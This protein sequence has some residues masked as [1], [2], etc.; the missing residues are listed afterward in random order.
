MRMQIV[1]VRMV[2]VGFKLGKFYLLTD[3]ISGM[4][5][6]IEFIHKG[7]CLDLMIF[8]LIFLKEDSAFL[9]DFIE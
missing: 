9:D 4:M 1:H 3:C 7:V 8:R 6:G 5:L 2:S